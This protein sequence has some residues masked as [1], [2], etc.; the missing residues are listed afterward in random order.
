M[1][2]ASRRLAWLIAGVALLAPSLAAAAQTSY[3]GVSNTSTGAGVCNITIE[4]F[5]TLLTGGG[6]GAGT[7]DTTPPIFNINCPVPAGQSAA[8]TAQQLVPCID[9]VLPSDYV[10]TYNPTTEVRIDRT[11]GTFTISIQENVPTQDIFVVAAGAPGADTTRLVAVALAMYL[12]GA[13]FLI[14]RRRMI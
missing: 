4:S 1:N 8:V 5:G 3:I 11:V 10:V 2:A 13:A 7:L 14:R 12:G 6:R 9:A